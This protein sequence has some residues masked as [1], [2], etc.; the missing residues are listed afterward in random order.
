MSLCEAAF[1]RYSL[2]IRN[3]QKMNGREKCSRKGT[4]KVT[5][6]TSNLFIPT[7]IAVSTPA[8]QV[9]DSDQARRYRLPR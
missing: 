3:C 4:V 8:T 1:F 2:T 6:V 9:P 7:V 5:L